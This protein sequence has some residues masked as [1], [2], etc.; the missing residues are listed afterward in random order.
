MRIRACVFSR[1]GVK[2]YQ[3]DLSKSSEQSLSTMIDLKTLISHNQPMVVTLKRLICAV[4][5][6]GFAC[7]YR[8]PMQ[9]FFHTD[10]PGCGMTR[11]IIAF[12]KLDFSA[13]FAYHPLFPLTLVV[14]IYCIGREKMYIGKFFE[15]VFL[16]IFLTLF[17]F[18]WLLL[19]L[20]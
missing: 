5:L 16:L 17:L 10:C 19:K 15:Q 8:C 20:L 2:F 3:K 12:L 18:R 11:A 14:A 7:V 1:I 9:L 6:L 4:G 13:A